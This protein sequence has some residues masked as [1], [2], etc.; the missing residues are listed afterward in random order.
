[1]SK[2]LL[3]KIL[4]AVMVVGFIDAQTIMVNDTYGN[5]E[6]NPATWS[7]YDSSC[8]TTEKP[9]GIGEGDCD[10]DYDCAGHL[11][12]GKNNC[13]YKFTNNKKL[14]VA[15]KIHASQIRVRTMENAQ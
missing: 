10:K 11:I 1:M 15:T 8:C 4:C 9:C 13:G 2:T 5:P 6:C 3:I 7:K 14:I 12:C